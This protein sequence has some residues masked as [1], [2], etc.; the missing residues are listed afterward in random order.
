MATPLPD[1]E[2]KKQEWHRKHRELES[3]LDE[4]ALLEKIRRVVRRAGQELAGALGKIRE[5]G[6][7]FAGE[8]EGEV[9]ELARKAEEQERWLEGQVREKVRGLKWKLD[10]LREGFRRLDTQ[11]VSNTA[12]ALMRLE[13]E[14]EDQRRD[15][16]RLKKEIEEGVGDL[17][18]QVDRLAGRLG[19]IRGYLDRSRGATFSLGEGEALYLAVDA[20]WKK[21]GK[22]SE[23]PDGVLHV[24][25][26]RVVMERKEKEGGFLGFGGKKVQG[27]LWEV[28][29][30]EVEGIR[31]E[32]QGLLGGVDLI[33]FRLKPGS[34]LGADE[35]TVEVKGG[36][37]ADAFA[38]ELRQ[39][40]EG[41]LDRRRAQGF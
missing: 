6:Y 28:A 35:I 10:D 22:K 37:D 5:D 39:A 38:E 14:L 24:T 40:L 32:Q 36:I 19:V 23:D 4:G 41:A 33:H 25:D 18:E 13:D 29:W 21:T 34:A 26:R 2:A 3:G 17:P 8:L 16:D 20:E 11:V 30:G 27:L 31:P 12:P 1:L 15:L 9:E 7:R